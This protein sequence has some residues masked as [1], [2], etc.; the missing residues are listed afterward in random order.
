MRPRYTYQCPYCSRHFTAIPPAT[1]SCPHCNSVLRIDYSGADLIREGLQ[2]PPRGATTLGGILAGALIGVLLA[3][4]A[5]GLIGGIVGAGLGS[6][7]EKR[8]E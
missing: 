7:A 3:G 5:G 8:G 2:P 4:A 6:A 1:I